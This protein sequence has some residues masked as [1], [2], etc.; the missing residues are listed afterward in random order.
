MHYAI[1][2]FFDEETE[3]RIRRLWH[4]CAEFYATDYM[5]RNNVIPHATLLV[6][7][8]KLQRVFNE[9]ECPQLDIKFSYINTFQGGSVV[10]I[11]VSKG[12]DINEIHQNSYNRAVKIGATVEKFYQ[13][14]NWVPHC[15]IAQQCN[16][17]LDKIISFSSFIGTSSRLGIVR[18]P[19]TELLS[20][21][22]VYVNGG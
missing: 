11:K 7:D 6:G 8:E 19:P 20:Q 1:E 3:Q 12:C 5:F 21:R 4:E 14:D 22:P 10:F 17:N 18:Y 13:P 9:M 2:L 15:T 16:K